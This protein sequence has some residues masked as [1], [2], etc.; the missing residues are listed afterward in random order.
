M[1]VLLILVGLSIFLAGFTLYLKKE[2]VSNRSWAYKC[3]LFP[4]LSILDIQRKWH[5]SKDSG[6]LQLAGLFI[7][8]IGVVFSFN[9]P[10]GSIKNSQQQ[11]SGEIEFKNTASIKKVNTNKQTTARNT[12]L[13]EQINNEGD[14]TGAG[15]MNKITKGVKNTVSEI[16]EIAKEESSN[17]ISNVQKNRG[18]AGELNNQSFKPD[19]VTFKEGRLR[20]KQGGNLF[21]DKEV[22][23]L[24]PETDFPVQSGFT[25]Q[26]QSEQKN[27]PEIHISWLED[28][29]SVPE[30]R[31]LNT[32]YTLEL[33]CE[34]VTDDEI[35]ASIIFNYVKGDFNG[36]LTG[37]FVASKKELP[38]N[39]VSILSDNKQLSSK[40]EI[41]SNLAE[42]AETKKESVPVESVDTS[43]IISKSVEKP[44]SKV[45]EVQPLVESL[46]PETGGNIIIDETDQILDALQ[47][48][49]T[50]IEGAKEKIKVENKDGT[51]NTSTVKVET[52]TVEE[53]PV[54]KPTLVP[55]TDIQEQ[56][57][58]PET[59]IV[60]QK[61]E[62]FWGKSVVITSQN[63]STAEGLLKELRKGEI[64]VEMRVGAGIME[65]LTPVAEFK[66]VEI[67]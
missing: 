40:P 61:L 52:A 38:V 60:L 44:P 35:N 67:K 32:D 20:F 25:L 33:I 48:E 7:L 6:L 29:A 16:S 59:A 22:I 31:I 55:H 24:L 15:L 27:G 37:T 12:N 64:A 43:K 14:V 3:L 28:E 21:G 54:P 34:L 56:Y 10:T 18:L 53:K 50:S 66:S 5:T 62:P 57:L 1:A 11:M 45:S 39:T 65:K 41:K 30:T 42:F 58:K 8:S 26:V 63:G 46:E 47:A 19:T 51:I 9:N 23:I 13:A 17:L 49:M 4:P 2:F 36:K